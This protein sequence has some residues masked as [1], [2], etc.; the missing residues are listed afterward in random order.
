[1]CD[2]NNLI[3]GFVCCKDSPL[4]DEEEDHTKKAV[5]TSPVLKPAVP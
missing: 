5:K 1:M 3:S 2:L 4:D